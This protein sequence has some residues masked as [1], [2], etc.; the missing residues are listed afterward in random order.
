ME[1]KYGLTFPQKNILLVEEFFGKSPINTIV[2]IFEIN[3]EFDK[4][5]CEKAVNKMVEV[6]DALRI[7]VFKENDN[8][9]QYIEKYNYFNVDYFDLENENA[10]K[11]K[12]L[13][14]ELTT[15]PFEILNSPLYYFAIVKTE[16]DK[17]HIF[18][19]LHH[20]VSDAWTFGNVATQLAE[21]VDMYT[22]GEDNEIQKPSYLE[23]IS[24][25]NEYISSEKFTKDKMFWE[26]YLEGFEEPV[27][28]KENN[29]KTL[30][31]AKRYT[32]RLEEKLNND[33]KEFCRRN[34]V[35]PY[36]VFMNALAIY[37]HRV[38]EK[39]D[40][41]IGT[42]VLNRSNF[43]EKK[44]MGMFVS[45]MPVRFK[46]D[47]KETFLEMC[48]K[49]S[50]ETMSLF[51]HQ[52]YPY[53]IM[54][55]D[56]REKN[57]VS[58]NLYEVMISYQNARAE[59]SDNE[60]YSSDWI[61]STKVQDQFAIHIMDMDETG[62]LEVHFD[63][64]VDLFEDI[65]I[66]YIAKRLFTII[67]DGINNNKTIETIEIMPEEEKN[68]ILYEFNDTKVDYPKD[69]TV[70]D[71]FEEQ[72]QKTPENIAI[73]F[74]GKELTYREL[75]NFID[76]IAYT[77]KKNN[78]NIGDNVA[79]VLKR[80]FEMIASM[81]AIMKIGACYI[82]IDVEFP[83]DRIKYILN[84]CNAKL[85]VTNIDNNEYD[86][87]VLNLNSVQDEIQEKV[88]NECALENNIYMIYTSGSTGNPKGVI[89]KQ[90]NVVNLLYSAIDAVELY[91]NRNTYCA[92]STY[93][94]DISVLEI[95]LSLCFGHKL[96]IAN[97][98]Q[99]KEPL[100]LRKLIKDN[101]CEIFFMT[102]TRM[103]I[104][105]SG[106]D[107][108]YCLEYAKC[109]MLGGEAFPKNIFD[110]LSKNHK[111]RIYD[112]YGP[113]E[114]TV[115]S[116]VKRITNGDDINIGK[117]LNN[118]TAYVLDKNNR[119]L[120]MY[121]EGEL[122]IGGLG[123]AEGYYN[124][125]TLTSQ[126]FIMFNGN[127]IYKSGDLVKMNSLGECEFLGRIDSQ[128]KLHGLRIELEEIEKEINSFD[129]II[130]TAVIVDE[131]ERLVA[132]YTS[133]EQINEKKLKECISKKLPKYMV[134]NYFVKV[135]RFETNSVGKINKKILPKLEIKRNVSEKPTSKVE[136]TI[137]KA[138]CEILDLS[139]IGIDE[140]F[141]ELG[142]D[143]LKA[144]E[145]ISK[146]SVKN[147]SVAY[148]DI[149]KNSS[150]KQL[151][152]LVESKKIE[153]KILDKDVEIEKVLENNKKTESKLK[154][155]ELGNVL[156]TGA[157]GFLGS[158]LLANIIDTTN[159][160]VYCLVRGK[161][162][163]PP[164]LRLKLVL[165][166]YFGEKYSDCLGKRIIVVEGDIELQNLTKKPENRIILLNNIDTVIHSAANVKHFGD[167]EAFYKANIQGTKNI[168]DFCVEYNKKLIHIS[169]L[170]VSGNILEGGHITQKYI[171]EE[172]EYD[173]TKLNVGQNL[174][175]IYAFS[176]FKAEEYVIRKIKN[177]LNAKIMRIGNIT[178][179]MKD[180]KFQINANENAFVGR[181]KS[182][183]DMRMVPN[184]LY[185]FDIEF[186]PVDKLSEAIIL[187]SKIEN[188]NNVFHVYNINHVKLNRFIEILNSIGYHVSIVDKEKFAERIL[189]IK[190]MNEFKT[191]SGIAI[192]LD[193]N[194]NLQYETNIKI[195]SESTLNILK[196]LGFKWPEIYEEYICKFIHELCVRNIIDKGDK[197]E[198]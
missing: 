180:G 187:L 96:I 178:G 145:F 51:R 189:E 108:I 135:D 91:D 81:F 129:N 137:A 157:T 48:K 147:I 154:T 74:E 156:L 109:I 29:N 88:E 73:V 161:K 146:L 163:V 21:Y 13:E 27:G 184:N 123:V 121:V 114:I 148:I 47:E 1:N 139:E 17:G 144:I 106:E 152:S 14:N 192:D 67:D 56:F 26:E 181:I 113:T 131:K 170:S 40:F 35:S 46:I 120:P 104:L 85:I 171:N 98:K 138:I 38:T 72:V 36:T 78:I 103:Q 133:D 84:D 110:R 16:K 149:F 101:K 80:G 76:K 118:T 61:F 33:I 45:T 58:N 3:K 155:K 20:L 7:K 124:K 140:D 183:I 122:C 176:K 174:E 69:K 23:F 15:K 53:S 136:K 159:S 102:P 93:S 70:I 63:Y 18:V 165:Q 9:F 175:N 179:R 77:L 182:I 11:R 125:D 158:H 193:E 168:T 19:K 94:F 55:Q 5:V 116:S 39:Y 64:L 30:I 164:E 160:I 89:I 44:M 32:V 87:K 194:N 151:A 166:E 99:Q 50:S 167:D 52:K 4:E 130:H 162:E 95:F 90:K 173:E 117:P 196:K 107:S 28:I 6:N 127:K 128:I 2:G 185:D 126:K 119:L 65:E 134:P 197:D 198:I 25:E 34:R 37:L 24:T 42:P 92:L 8:T 82:P 105:L 75:S 190:K 188:S 79:L 66:E 22:K 150:V 12:E 71:L 43:K 10:E 111:I 68:K 115:W 177:G 83:K 97:E 54:L 142:L 86:L 49:S 186:T 143:S 60:K 141:F 41:V 172:I 100:E 57:N 132:Y 169:T 112:G 62:V 59:Y 191:I 153:Y 31:D 195:K